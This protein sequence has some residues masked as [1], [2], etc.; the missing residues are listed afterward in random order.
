M[1]VQEVKEVQENKSEE[2]NANKK[3]RS[4]IAKIV[5][6]IIVIAVIVAFR[7]ELTV[8]NL[9][10]LIEVVRE[11]PYA[12]ILFVVIYAVAVTLAIPASALTLISG[13]IFGFWGGL[14]LTIV[15][16]NLGCHLSYFVAKIIG[17]DAVERFVK[18]GS[19]I[20][21]AKEKAKNNGFVF[22]MYA[23]LIPL[24]PF[25]VV[26]YLSGIIGIRY[27]DYSIA[28]FLG[29]IPGSAVYVYLGYSA[30]NIQDNPMGI[31]ISVVV[32]VLFTVG[33][34]IVKK[35]SDSV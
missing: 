32:L 35:R 15:G 5:I 8:E 1:M 30:S 18:S 6:V 4:F 33:I 7:D 2:N 10:A 23:R 11:N 19:F 34:A 28:T 3:K 31:I 20:E 21:R 9:L 27:R 22:M 14:L 16:A 25:A 26:N 24:F 12:P 13:P 29:M 17:K